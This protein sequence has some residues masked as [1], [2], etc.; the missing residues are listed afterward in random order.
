M[1]MW[2]VEQKLRVSAAPRESFFLLKQVEY[3]GL[4]AMA[5]RKIGSP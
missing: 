2:R 1:T 5:A 3:D 4:P